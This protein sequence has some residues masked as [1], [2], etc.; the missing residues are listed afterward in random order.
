MVE[1]E[2]RYRI[3]QILANAVKNVVDM[4]ALDLF[5]VVGEDDIIW[6]AEQRGIEMTWKFLE[7]LGCACPED[8]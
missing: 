8:Y 4:V 7:D 1:L 3:F 5:F 2:I 6:Y